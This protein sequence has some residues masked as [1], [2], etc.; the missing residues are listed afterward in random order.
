MSQ[1]EEREE[2]MA[3]LRNQE[4][5]TVMKLFA[6]ACRLASLPIVCMLPFSLVCSR[7]RSDHES[8]AVEVARLLPDVETMQLAIK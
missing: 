2:S 3:S 6:L 7:V 8:R 1:T 4:V 5:A